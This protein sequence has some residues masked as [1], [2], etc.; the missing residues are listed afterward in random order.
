MTMYYGWVNLAIAALA[1]VATLPGRTQGLGLVTEP[2]ITEL[3]ISRLDF[4]AINLWATL[5]GALFTFPFG[6][7]VDRVGPRLVTAA[8]LAL[9]GGTV[10]WMSDSRGFWPLAIAVT[11]TRGFGQSALSAASLALAGK[12]FAR[13]LNLAMG[14]FALL[15]AIGFIAAFPAVGS[16]VTSQGWRSAWRGIGLALLAIAPIAGLFIRNQPPASEREDV[17]G[18]AKSPEDLTLGE[19][20]RTPAFWV[21]GLSSAI[22]GLVYSGI[23]LFNESIL[24]QRGF[25]AA[26]YHRTL[27]ISTMLGLVANFAGG[28]AA[29]RWDIRKLTGIGM[30]VLS[31]SLLLL[32]RVNALPQVDVYAALMGIAG[33]IVTVVFF[34][35]WGQAFGRSHLGRIQGFA[36]MLTVLASAIGPLLLARTLDATGSYDSIFHLLAAIV[37]L[38]AVAAT[39]APMPARPARVPAGTG[40]GASPA[41]S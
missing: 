24:A 27:V 25:D 33:G 17:E 7:W 29:Q 16:A 35:V 39:F 30:A 36:Q 22:F 19:A 4:A 8:L 34:S 11:L 1:M 32:P 28:W 41:R 38:L 13:R 18:I 12:W 15:V 6:H 21:F 20:L 2:L 37:F 23:A 5:A 26:V 31:A 3:Q 14:I 9:L 10:V 40:F